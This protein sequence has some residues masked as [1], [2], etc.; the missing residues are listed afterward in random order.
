MRPLS[1]W[2]RA[3]NADL[4]DDGS[5]TMYESTRDGHLN[6]MGCSDD[7]VACFDAAND[8]SRRGRTDSDIPGCQ[9]RGPVFTKAGHIGV[10]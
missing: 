3:A 10:G 4:F 2:S 7:V 9:F 6:I 5:Q 1:H 8:C